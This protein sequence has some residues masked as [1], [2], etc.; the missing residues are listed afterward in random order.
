MVQRIQRIVSTV[1]RSWLSLLV[2]LQLHGG[3]LIF[4]HLSILL[5]RHQWYA[6][7]IYFSRYSVACCFPH[8][9]L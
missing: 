3:R 1:P 4:I 9:R 2:L 5:Y 8:G 6:I 7:Y